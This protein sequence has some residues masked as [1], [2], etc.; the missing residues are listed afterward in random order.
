M[1]PYMGH[2]TSHKIVGGGRV[3]TNAPVTPATSREAV[4]RRTRRMVA[5]FATD[6]V[7][8][9]AI[10][11]SLGGATARAVTDEEGYYRLELVEADLDDNRLL[12]PIDVE[13][14]APP[15]GVPVFVGPAEVMVP[16]ARA[17]RLIISDIDD[18]VLESGVTRTMQMVLTT[19]TG[20]VW[21]RTPFAGAA[22]LYTGLARGPRLDQDNP[23]FYVSS[24]PWN[25]YDFLHGFIERSV[26]PTGPL[27]LRD[28][29]IDDKKFVAGSHDD[30]KR[31]AIEEILEVHDLP[32]VLVGDTN[33]RDP[34]I[35]H[36]VAQDHPD[37]V[38]AILLRA[39]HD[40]GRGESLRRRYGDTK[41]PWEMGSD[42][43]ELAAAAE[44][45]GLVAPG[46]ADRVR[47]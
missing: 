16:T 6:E 33:Q 11:A 5:R 30:H 14:E 24:S 10:V 7:A 35:Y 39:T 9:I 47:V 26:L 4:W 23:F 1:V 13:V 21:T 43:A 36:A 32:A 18:T 2:G 27:F 12:H 8:G 20:S 42:S 29:G 28:L 40:D 34:E 45:M 17:E 44:E 37:R 46:W 25:L 3:L 31:A 22:R 15:D 41:V 38:E 19:M